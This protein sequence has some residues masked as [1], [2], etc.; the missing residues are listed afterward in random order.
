MTHI[1]WCSFCCWRAMSQPGEMGEEEER[2]DGGRR[3]G[4]RKEQRGREK[5]ERGRN[6]EVR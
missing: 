3:V 1:H 4:G 2:R 6:K 5:G